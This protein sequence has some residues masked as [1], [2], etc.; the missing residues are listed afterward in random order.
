[1][2][3]KQIKEHREAL[4]ITQ[5]EMGRDTGFNPKAIARWEAGRV[6]PM[7]ANDEILVAYFRKKGRKV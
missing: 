5:E 3:G 4:G 6:K 7:R 2:E 1:M